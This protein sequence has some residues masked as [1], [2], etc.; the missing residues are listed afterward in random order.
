MRHEL[1]S[2]AEPGVLT[3]TIPQ[4]IGVRSIRQRILAALARSCAE[5]T[6]ACTTIAD[7]VAGASVSRAT[8]YKHFENKREC[9]DA[10]AEEFLGELHAAASD[11]GS[12]SATPSEA[13]RE[14]AAALLRRLA[15]KPA[16]AR[17]LLVEAPVVNPAILPRCR[18]LVVDAMEGRW[19]RTK[20]PSR[21]GADPGIAFGRANVLLAE[22]LSADADDD[23]LASLLPEVLYIALLPYTG[24]DK[25]LE[26]AGAP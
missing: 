20:T 11:V 9:F 17:L 3:P 26:L 4:D 2:V 6:F 13:T 18:G 22:H 16:F 24:Q 10:A 19:R 25:A 5:K 21:P 8:F 12:E 1:G 15:E 14:A 7:I 23:D